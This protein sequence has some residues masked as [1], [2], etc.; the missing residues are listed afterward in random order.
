M[1]KRLLSVALAVSM[2]AAM[3]T[4][5]GSGSSDEANSSAQE[6]GEGKPT[7]SVFTDYVESNS[8]SV[9][10]NFNKALEQTKEH[11]ADKYNIE[12]EAVA[13]ESYKEKIKAM[14]A[15][16]ET[17]DIFMTWGAGFM[18]SF[19]DAGKVAAIDDYISEESKESLKTGALDMFEF[20]GK[21]Y[22]LTANKWVGALY[23]NKTLF[24]ENNLEIPTT[25]DELIEVCK[26]FREKG[27]QPIALGAKD[28]WP[29][30]QY[31][32][33]F[34]IQLAGTDEANKMAFKE[35]SLDNE[36][37][38]QAC[39]YVIEMIDAG[40]FNDGAMGLSNE[41]AYAAFTRGENPMMYTNS[42]Y[43]AQAIAEDSAIKD[44]VTAVRFPL[45]DEADP[46]QYF[47]GAID[48]LCMSSKC[49]YPEETY[50][51]MEY[52]V[53]AWA[54]ADGGLVTWE[55][56]DE[57]KANVDFLNQEIIDYSADATGYSLAWDTLFD[58]NDAQTWLDL[59]SEVYAGN[60]TS[61]EEF[62]KQL[63]AGIGE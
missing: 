17:P 8:E 37:V 1:K 48:G 33:E 9:A 34:V 47:G 54:E 38:A 11:F 63:Q 29:C 5:C 3:L 24:E 23:C 18:E 21:A 30:Q 52:L 6:G 16:D 56:S 20:D 45:L 15:A 12:S 14:V 4:G 22:G 46:N 13:I 25:F 41:E 61:G 58:S 59:V 53:R 32:N 28:Q 39:D 42:N 10:V 50:E 51:V 40:A 35:T 60:I 31:I 62:A 43:S 19:V 44:S 7:I 26:T 2:T 27:I 57:A 49:E 36:Y 55:V